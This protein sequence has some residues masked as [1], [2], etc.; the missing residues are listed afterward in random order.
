MEIDGEGIIRHDGKIVRFCFKEINFSYNEKREYDKDYKIL[1]YTNWSNLSEEAK[2][3]LLEHL[4]DIPG[5]WGELFKVLK[6]MNDETN[7]W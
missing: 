4:E 2:E 5:E 7:V 1:N 6:N 3:V